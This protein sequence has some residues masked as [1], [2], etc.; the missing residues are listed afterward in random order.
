MRKALGEAAVFDRYLGRLGYHS[1][2]GE[3]HKEANAWADA[4]T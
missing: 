4:Q 3:D 1:D 2:F